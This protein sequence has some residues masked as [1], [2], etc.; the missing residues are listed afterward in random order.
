MRGAGIVVLAALLAACDSMGIHYLSEKNPR[1]GTSNPERLD[2]AFW[3]HMI[4]TGGNA[5]SARK[6]FGDTH[7]LKNGPVWTFDRLG[8]TRTKLPDGSELCV[9][10]EHEDYYD[11]DFNIYNDVVLLK[12]GAEPE[13]YV[14]PK[15]VFPPTD[16]HTAT[17]VD[18]SLY[19]IGALG[20]LDDRRPKT[21]PV[22]RL[23][24]ATKRIE[25]VATTGTPPGWIHKHK[26]VYDPARRAIVVS[27]GTV[28][29]ANDPNS[30]RDNFDD[31]RLSLADGVWGRLTDRRWHQ[32]RVVLPPKRWLHEG[33]RSVKIDELLPAEPHAL[34]ADKSAYEDTELEQVV[35]YGVRRIVVRG[36]TVLYREGLRNVDVRIEGVLPESLVAAL[37]DDLRAK[38]G[39]AVGADCRVERL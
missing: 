34:V 14:Y 7:D 21:T 12:P 19:I 39:K 27:G 6:D 1:F 16:F 24:V 23:D 35:G 30:L 5:Y 28:Q 15:D 37:A 10:G 29:A 2:L 17:L 22:Y 36:V 31:Y 13:I 4:K 20:Y 33:Q 25:K 26:A 38:L 9:G 11:P 32:F 18:G 8:M 3:K